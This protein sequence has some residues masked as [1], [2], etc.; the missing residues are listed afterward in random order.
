MNQT[1][2]ILVMQIAAL[3]AAF[4]GGWTINGW[5]LDATYQA[6]ANQRSKAAARQLDAAYTERDAKAAALTTAN[7]RNTT[8]FREAQHATNTFRDCIADGTCG[9]RIAATCPPA[10]NNQDPTAPGVDNGAGAEL[11]AIARRPYFAL[12][13]G[14]DRASAQLAACQDEL[15]IR[16]P[17]P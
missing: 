12:R 4:G 15:K 6:E 10:A 1:L 14:I 9:L 13:D 7:D 8:K 17:A 5:R 2:I 16:S 11:A 3:A